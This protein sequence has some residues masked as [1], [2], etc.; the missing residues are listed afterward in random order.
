MV[1]AVGW[2]GLR[3]PTGPDDFGDAATVGLHVMRRGKGFQDLNI[4]T[5]FGLYMGEQHFAGTS[6]II[7]RQ[8]CVGIIDAGNNIT[9]FESFST[10]EELKREWRLV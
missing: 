2:T 6:A 8:W 5:D 3:R 4:E 1:S 10:L 7:H 9:G